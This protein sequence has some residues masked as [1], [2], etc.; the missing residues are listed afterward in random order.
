VIETARAV[1]VAEQTSDLEPARREGAPPPQ[2]RPPSSEAT[3]WGQAIP[4]L[5][6]LVVGCVGVAMM[7]VVDGAAR[8]W[9]LVA[10]NV[11]GAAAAATSSRRQRLVELRPGVLLLL[12]LVLLVPA[13]TLWYPLTIQLGLTP[14]TPSAVDALFLAA[15]G[16]FIA[17]LLRLIRLRGGEHRLVQLIDS[18]IISVGLGVLAWVLL[19]SPYL[20]DEA[21]SLPTKAVA[22]SYP[23]IDVVLC[24]L[25]VRLLFQTRRREPAEWLLTGWVTLQ[26]LADL[27]YAVTTLRG[28]FDLGRPVVAV[29]GLSFVVLGAAFLHPSA[30]MIGRP[31]TERRAPTGVRRLLVVG[32]ATSIPPIVLLVLGIRGEVRDVAVV[33][34][35]SLVLFVLVLVRIGLLM[36]DVEEH[37]QIQEELLSSISARQLQEADLADARDSALDASRAKSEFLATMSHEIRTPMNGVI[38]LTE[39]L[40]DTSLDPVQR[41][42]ATGVHGAGEALLSIIDDILDF[43]KLEAGKVD[44]EATDFDPRQ[45]V[46]DVGLLLAGAASAKGLELTAY[47]DPDVPA[48]LLGDAGRLKQILLNLTSNAVKFTEDGEVS[49]HARRSPAETGPDDLELVVTDTGMGIALEDQARMFEPFSQADASTTRRFGGTGL[50]LAI[51]RRLVDAMGG[52]LDVESRPGVGTTFRCTLPMTPRPGLPGLTTPTPALLTGMSVLVVDDN[53]TNRLILQN[54]LTAWGMRPTV[55]HDGASA[56]RALRTAAR[57]GAPYPIAILDWCMP[58]MDGVTV[59]TQ[60]AGDVGLRSTRPMLLSS[61]GPVDRATADAAG[62]ATCINKPVRLSELHD[63]LVLLADDGAPG[64]AVARPVA[65]PSAPAV[66]TR[67]RVL[68]AEDNVVNQM[69]AQGVLRKLGY[70]VEMVGDGREALIAMESGG[71]DL[72]LMDCHMPEVD[73]FQATVEWRRREGVGPRL[74]IVAMTAGVLAADRENCIAAGMDDFVPKPID[75]KLLERTMLKWTDGARAAPAAS[76]V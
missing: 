58:D 28:T 15:Y 41:R 24:G 66:P 69:V 61:A 49:V 39:L 18:L 32:A 46:E 1:R 27:V 12:G 50:G 59:A 35:I 13:Y 62:L 53:E 19:I 75:V 17:A 71:F 60:I 43:S 10:L 11:A 7:Q 40:L 64:A 23:L 65:P 74:P 16:C 22:V 34:L 14:P 47:C 38:G 73:G 63:S 72:V 5:T 45:V 2:Q 67:G 70:D 25:M 33:A 26:L 76:P 21:L 8:G 9:L 30:R 51:C 56:L 68:V 44:L 3:S 36:V 48:G 54:Q 20:H 55:V 57:D 4:C 37:R 29:Y 42:Y 52:R 6:F 31:A